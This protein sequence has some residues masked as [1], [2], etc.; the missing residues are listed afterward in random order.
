M[1]TAQDEHLVLIR[2]V[3]RLQER[4]SV[5]V[6]AAATSLR[7]QEAE[8]VRLRGELLVART[9]ALWG[10][11]WGEAQA[12]RLDLAHQVICQTGCVGHAHYWLGD[13]GNC[14]RT[15]DPCDRLIK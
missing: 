14:Q 5:F 9:A 4:M 11:A 12:Q 8:I 2:L 13:D 1:Q 15:G 10:L 3:G 7:L 6:T